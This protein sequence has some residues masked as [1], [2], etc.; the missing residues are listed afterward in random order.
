MSRISIGIPVYNG[1]NYLGQALDSLLNQTFEDF[2]I[3]ISDNASTDKTPDICEQYAGEDDR[4]KYIRNT[5]NRGAAYNFNHLVDISSAPYFKWAAHDDIHAPEFLEKCITVLDSNKSIVLCSTAAAD[6]DENGDE[7]GPIEDKLRTDSVLP[8]IRFGD[9]VRIVH[10]CVAVFGVIRTEVLRKTA[11]IGEYA[12]SDRNLLAELS[13]YGIL[14][15]IP[16]VLFYR[17]EHASRSV[18][19]FSSEKE[20]VK[21]FNP[22]RS[23]QLHFPTFI[24][25]REYIKA[26]YRAPL[27]PKE[28]FLCYWQIIALAGRASARQRIFRE[29]MPGN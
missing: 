5:E 14:Y 23:A 4:I 3:I 2:E 24:R 25:M 9:L 22:G 10:Q 17:R 7:I 20:R 11:L 26:I 18:R 21:W 19:A 13:L 27:T 6:I 1:E 12:A 16:E 28:Q 15:E 8:H 29:L